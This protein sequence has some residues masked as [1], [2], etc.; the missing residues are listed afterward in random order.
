MVQAFNGLYLSVRSIGPVSINDFD[1]HLYPGRNVPGQL[2]LGE[3]SPANGVQEL[4]AHNAGLLLTR[5]G[6]KVMEH[7]DALSTLTHNTNY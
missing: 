3:G 6:C 2:H 4:I 5:G 1:S 7:G